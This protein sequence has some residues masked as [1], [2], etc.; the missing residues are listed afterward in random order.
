MHQIVAT[1]HDF[2]FSYTETVLVVDDPLVA[3]GVCEA[4]N[5][6][7][8]AQ[9]ARR[10]VEDGV[11]FCVKPVKVVMAQSERRVPGLVDRVLDEKWP[12]R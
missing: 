6:L 4:L 8:P 9:R 2:D 7:T 3:R 12:R 11:T 5:A 10:G 1:R